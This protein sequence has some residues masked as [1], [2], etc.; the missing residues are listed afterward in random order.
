MACGLAV[1]AT[2]VGGTSEV[3]R[4]NETGLL[5]PAGDF[6]SLVKA[7]EAAA[8]DEELR[9][10]LARCGRELVLTQHDLALSLRQTEGLIQ[11]ALG[12]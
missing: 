8:A 7:C 10:R 6:W 1:V 5:V 9:A 4:V 3:V 12:S 2:D 11:A